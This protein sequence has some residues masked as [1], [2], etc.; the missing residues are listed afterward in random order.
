MDKNQDFAMVF[1]ARSVHNY[2]LMDNSNVPAMAGF[3]LLFWVTYLGENTMT[4][5]TYA[6]ERSTEVI[7]L[8][9]TESSFWLRITSAF[10]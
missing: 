7:K 5:L 8:D 1:P 2:I 4:I 6:L 10:K 3:T 9:I